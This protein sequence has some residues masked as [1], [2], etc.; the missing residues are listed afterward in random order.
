MKPL[1]APIMRSGSQIWGRLKCR[2]EGEGDLEKKT[3]FRGD[4]V[5]ERGG[6]VWFPCGEGGLLGGGGKGDATSKPVFGSLSN[7]NGLPVKHR[8]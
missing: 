8:L 3:S 2:V 4:R 6:G 5:G 1:H 7:Q